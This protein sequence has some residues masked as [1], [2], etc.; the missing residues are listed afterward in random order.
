MKTHK[1]LSSII[2][3]GVFLISI[4]VNAAP[5]DNNNETLNIVEHVN[6]S[7]QLKTLF[8]TVRVSDLTEILQ[9]DGPF[10][11]FAPSDE[12]FSKLPEGM[13]LSLINPDN[14]EELIKLLANHVII[15]EINSSDLTSGMITK[16]VQG[17]SMK[18]YVSGDVVKINGS[19]IMTSDIKASNGIVHVVDQVILP[20]LK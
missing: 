20:P 19:R 3:L 4:N 7:E 11:I 8:A 16:N 15:G 17:N 5:G 18:I 14:K 13:L 12:A 9:S 6:A 10:T 1:N 2:L